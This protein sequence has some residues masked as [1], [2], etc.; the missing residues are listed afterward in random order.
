MERPTGHEQEIQLL[1]II[2]MLWS[3]KFIIVSMTALS[4]IVGGLLYNILPRTYE[5]NAVITPTRQA[6]FANFLSLIG[7]GVFPYTRE[8]LLGEFVTYVRDMS[9]L[10]AAA[11]DSGVV[12]RDG[13]DD[14]LYQRALVSFARDVQ[15][16]S[17]DK[18]PNVLRMRVQSEDPEALNKFTLLVLGG[19]NARF[20]KDLSF[21]ISQ[22]VAAGVEDRAEQRSR[23]ELEIVALRQKAEAQRADRIEWLG[24]QAKIARSL[25]L[26]R[27]IEMRNP[28]PA[29]AGEKV[30]AQV[31]SDST[32]FFFRGY[33]AIDE[34]IQLLQQR[35]EGDAFVE[36]LRELEQKVYLLQNDDQSTRVE[37]LLRESKLGDPEHV[38]LAQYDAEAAS[39]KRIAPKL[40]IFAPASL[41]I[42]LGLGCV[43]AL[44]RGSY[45]RRRTVR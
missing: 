9:L 33:L 20:A 37:R 42:G 36:E 40:S 3:G 7:A 44:L 43:A 32:P 22:Q 1:D 2:D 21:E 39:A 10:R 26:D 24:E 25:E 15:F 11:A 45:A 14:V 23:L 8:T 17:S 13:R 31:R 35:K 18:E 29:V 19:A 34:E 4:V 28:E 5:S 6:N 30:S 12:Q 41:L 27:P 16:T 38:K